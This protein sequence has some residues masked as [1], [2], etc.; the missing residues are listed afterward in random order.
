MTLRNC[1]RGN[2]SN[3]SPD[4]I[5]SDPPP[6]FWVAFGLHPEYQ[7]S[8]AMTHR[9]GVCSSCD[10]KYKIPASFTASQAKCKSC[11]GVVNISDPEGAKK[12]APPVPTKQVAQVPKPAPKKPELDEIKGSG[13]K[14]SGPSMKERLL[15]ERQAAEAQQAKPAAKPARPARRSS[16]AKAEPKETA[17]APTRETAKASATRG[18]KRTAA[19]SSRRSGARGSKR[20]GEADAEVAENEETAP[21]G[22]RG[23]AKKKSPLLPLMSV[24]ALVLA[25]VGAFFFMQNEEVTAAEESS[26]ADTEMAANEAKLAAEKAAAD[27]EAMDKE[28]ADATESADATPEPEAEP[29]KPKE[30]APKKGPD[31]SSVD[32]T[33]IEDF[34]PVDGMS[35]E[36]FDDLVEKT[37]MMIDPEAGAAGNR[38]RTALIKAG[39]LAFPALLNKFKTLDFSTE[40]GYRDGDLF[41]KSLEEICG[42]KNFGWRYSAE[43]KDELFNKKVVKNWSSNWRVAQDDPA[44]W[45]AMAGVKAKPVEEAEEFSEDSM[46]DLDDF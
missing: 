40:Q 14:R 20:R 23:A 25:G 42:G 30:E 18:S 17:G 32:L 6:S 37:N 4:P 15:A 46:D 29:E 44:R 13:K 16:A 7:K 43:P 39:R 34:G 10:A 1:Q 19:G 45:E 27:M 26:M 12:A 36:D 24:A 21:R 8:T 35:Q 38:S 11:G 5:H 41:Q 3:N 22:R 2:S 28:A 9:L 31:P 33:A